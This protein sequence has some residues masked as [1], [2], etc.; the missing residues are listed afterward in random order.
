LLA[1]T[2]VTEQSATWSFKVY[3]PDAMFYRDR[4]LSGQQLSVGKSIQAED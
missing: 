4:L 1:A 2:G 3:A